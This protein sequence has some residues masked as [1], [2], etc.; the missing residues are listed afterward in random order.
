MWRRIRMNHPLDLNGIK[1]LKWP[2]ATP[3]AAYWAP[4]DAS[5]DVNIRH[6][7]GLPLNHLIPIIITVIDR[8]KTN[9][10]AVPRRQDRVALRRFRFLLPSHV[11]YCQQRKHK[12][13]VGVASP[14]AKN[15]VSSCFVLVRSR[16]FRWKLNSN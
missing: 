15:P 12:H 6:C 7:D 4:D 10:W 11:V 13:G 1:R 16:A 14:S 8:K 2:L 3:K 9:F 5:S